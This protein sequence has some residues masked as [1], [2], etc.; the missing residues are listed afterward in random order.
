MHKNSKL[1]ELL[2]NSRFDEA[3]SL[4]KD[5]LAKAVIIDP[6][7]YKDESWPQYADAISRKIS[8][9]KGQEA[10]IPFWEDLLKFFKKELEPTW[11]HLHKGHILFRLGIANLINDVSIAKKYLEKALDED[12]LLEIERA[13]GKSIDIENKIRKYSAYVMLCIIERIKYVKEK[14]KFFQE[15][16]SPSFDAAIRGDKVDP[17]LVKEAVEYIV[18]QQGWEQILETRKELD[19]VFKLKLKTATISLTGAFLENILLSILYHHLNLS[20]AQGKNILEAELGKLLEEAIK[21]SIFPSDSIKTACRTINIFRNRLH[22]GNELTQKYKLTPR[23]AVTIKIFFDSVLVDW[24]KQISDKKS[25][26]T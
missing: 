2:N 6:S 10:T 21:R 1:N 4:L 14:Q 24:A 12:R 25:A 8:R 20:T 17:D 9:D 13:K 15:L 11:E 16:L 23:V 19:L 22:P 7:D 26:Q 18:P 5:H 3:A